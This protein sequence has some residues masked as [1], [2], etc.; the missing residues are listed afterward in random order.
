MVTLFDLELEKLDVK[1][2]FLHGELEKQIIYMHQ[3]E[4]FI[5]SGKE[6]HVCLLKKSLYGLKKSLYVN[7]YVFCFLPI[8]IFFRGFS[9]QKQQSEVFSYSFRI[10]NKIIEFRNINMKYFIIV[11]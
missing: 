9:Q 10:L 8:I 1:I 4:G 7:Y 2:L 11:L 6:D 5:I 3:L